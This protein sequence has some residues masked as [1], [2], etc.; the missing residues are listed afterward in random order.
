LRSIDYDATHAINFSRPENL[1]IVIKSQLDTVIAGHVISISI[2]PMPFNSIRLRQVTLASF[3]AV[4]VI[5]ALLMKLLC[6][7]IFG[8]RSIR[9][10]ERPE[11]GICVT[12]VTGDF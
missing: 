12:N 7:N 4:T 6:S 1:S 9:L 8:T 2:Q 5:V 10:P 3:I 11:K